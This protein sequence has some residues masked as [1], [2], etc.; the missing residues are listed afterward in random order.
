M[1]K[2]IKLLV[3]AYNEMKKAGDKMVRKGGTDG[4]KI[5]KGICTPGGYANF[6]M[7]DDGPSAENGLL[8][9]IHGGA[10]IYGDQDLNSTYCAVFARQGFLT[11]S[12]GYS[13]L[14]EVD[15]RGQMQSV[16][17]GMNSIYTLSREYGFSG[18]KVKLTGDSCGAHLIT[19]AFATTQDPVLKKALGVPDMIFEPSAMALT[20]PVCMLDNINGFK[21]EKLSIKLTEEIKKMMMPTESDEKELEGLISFEN[22]SPHMEFPPLFI[23]SSEADVF[24]SNSKRMMECLD[25]N[26]TSYESLFFDKTYKDCNHV[27]NVAEPD[28]KEAKEA[29][30]KIIDFFL[31][32]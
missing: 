28:K 26:G 10:W 21:S 4:V 27:F 23:L 14:P 6:Y 16:I 32:N 20:S 30:S 19:L 1:D 13:L 31:S 7:R 29:N 15:I 17:S 5:E 9:D 25:K 12:L 2:M 3:K 8:I 11:A 18:K 22:Y 24:Y